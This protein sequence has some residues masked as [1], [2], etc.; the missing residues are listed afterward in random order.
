[1]AT[2]DEGALAHARPVVAEGEVVVGLPPAKRLGRCN[3]GSLGLLVVLSRLA[4]FTPS[5]LV[6]ALL[7]VVGPVVLLVVHL[8]H[9]VEAFGLLLLIGLGGG[10]LVHDVFLAVDVE[11]AVFLAE[12]GLQ[13]INSGLNGRLGLSVF[14]LEQGETCMC[15]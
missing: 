11:V 7:A 12:L 15:W 1:M 3:G 14:F 5:G 9:L 13:L 4:I 2:V 6:L 10:L 8:V